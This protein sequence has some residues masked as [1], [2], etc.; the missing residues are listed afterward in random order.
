MNAYSALADLL[1]P[2]LNKGQTAAEH[3]ESQEPIRLL[4]RMAADE[5]PPH[6]EQLTILD[7]CRRRVLDPIWTIVPKGR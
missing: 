6:R 7:G 2:R 3:L 1:R 5:L 4:P